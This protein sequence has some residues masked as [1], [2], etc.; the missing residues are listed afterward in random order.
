MQNGKDAILLTGFGVAEHD[1][2]GGRAG[3]NR[4]SEAGFDRSRPVDWIRRIH[5]HGIAII[6]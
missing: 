3:L 2:R 4:M 6:I 5:P 1:L